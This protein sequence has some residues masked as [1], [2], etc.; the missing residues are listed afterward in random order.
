MCVCVCVGGVVCGVCVC[1]CVCVCGVCVCVC[2]C[3]C[4]VCVCGVCVCVC[5]CVEVRPEASTDGVPAG[6]YGDG[7]GCRL[8]RRTGRAARVELRAGGAG[9]SHVLDSLRPQ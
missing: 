7:C 2:V 1:V 9:S 4:V 6:G 3:V 8:S 5:V